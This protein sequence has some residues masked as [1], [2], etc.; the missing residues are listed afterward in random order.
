VYTHSLSLVF[1]FDSQLFVGMLLI[2]QP[3]FIGGVEDVTVAKESAFGAMYAFMVTFLFS[4][5]MWYRDVKRKRREF[6]LSRHVYA[7]VDPI[8]PYEINLP[9]HLVPQQREQQGDLTTRQEE[10]DEIVSSLLLPT[11]DHDLL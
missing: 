2:H 3:F 4:L 8:E 9:S 7:P 6:V 10:E 5:V 1:G 11:T